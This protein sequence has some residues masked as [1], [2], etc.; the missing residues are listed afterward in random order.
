MLWPMIT[1]TEY[2][3]GLVQGCVQVGVD[4]AQDSGVKVGRFT[5]ERK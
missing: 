4:S 3:R 1:F 2:E 5:P